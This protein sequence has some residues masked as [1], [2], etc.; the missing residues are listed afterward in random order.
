MFDYHSC[1]KHLGVVWYENVMCPDCLLEHAQNLVIAYQEGLKDG[2]WEEIQFQ[3]R[4]LNPGKPLT[5]HQI[6]SLE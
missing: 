5:E 2:H 4:K 1:G 3:Q 6:N